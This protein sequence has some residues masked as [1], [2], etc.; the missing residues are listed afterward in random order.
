MPPAQ[1]CVCARAR[2]CAC[3]LA[4]RTRGRVLRLYVNARADKAAAPTSKA[5]LA[6]LRDG[7]SPRGVA[8]ASR[9][10]CVAARAH[11]GRCLWRREAIYG[12]PRRCAYLTASLVD[13][14]RHLVASLFISSLFVPSLSIASSS[15]T[16]RYA[17]GPDAHILAAW[18]ARV[19]DAHARVQGVLAEQAREPARATACARRQCECTSFA[20]SVLWKCVQYPVVPISTH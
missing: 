5:E 7:Q 20:F 4:T 1:V 6:L 12:I 18:R 16:L 2:A 15:F 13:F 8:P 19:G 11:S 10:V 14:Q 9:C 3:V 17:A